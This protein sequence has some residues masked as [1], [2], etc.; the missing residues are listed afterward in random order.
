MPAT[1]QQQDSWKKPAKQQENGSKAACLKKFRLL[2]LSE[3][4]NFFYCLNNDY[5]D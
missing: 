1:N 4:L 3:I 2:L 5:F